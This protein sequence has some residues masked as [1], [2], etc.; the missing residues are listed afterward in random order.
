MYLSIENPLIKRVVNEQFKIIGE[1]MTYEC[2]P[3]FVEIGKTKKKIKWWEYY[4]FENQAQY[5][6][7]K[8][9]GKAIMKEGEMEKMFD[10]LDM[11]YG[12][13]YRMI[14]TPKAGQLALL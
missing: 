5:L 7:W 10:L 11:T 9:W 8:E 6:K 4:L 14:E 1:K 13:N 3:E 12:L 2:L